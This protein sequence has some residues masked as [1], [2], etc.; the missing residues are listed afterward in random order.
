MS[1]NVQHGLRKNC[2]CL[3]F[4]AKLHTWKVMTSNFMFACKQSI[5][6]Y[7][8]KSCPNLPKLWR[9]RGEEDVGA[10]ICSLRGGG[11]KQVC[12]CTQRKGTKTTQLVSDKILFYMW[13]DES[14]DIKEIRAADA[15]VN[16]ANCLAKSQCKSSLYQ[17]LSM[18]QYLE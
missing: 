1:V 16:K 6:G 17:S 9:R 4:C 13:Q 8:A 7:V 2:M 18:D 3:Q 14:S 11:G 10:Q 5:S 15:T 12:K